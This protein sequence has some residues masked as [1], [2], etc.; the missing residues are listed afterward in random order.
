ME[1]YK[2]KN[3]QAIANKVEIKSK[4]GQKRKI[5]GEKII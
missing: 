3:K 1:K 5:Y 4:K 2:K